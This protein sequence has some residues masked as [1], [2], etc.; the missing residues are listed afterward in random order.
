MAY[1]NHNRILTVASISGSGTFIGNVTIFSPTEP[2][3]RNNGGDLVDGDP[4][5][6]TVEFTESIYYDG[7]WIKIGALDEDG[8]LDGGNSGPGPENP[9]IIDGGSSLPHATDVR[10]IDGGNAINN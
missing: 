4:W 7:R 6:S 1:V 2:T 8:D 10:T 3:A 5:I 9:F